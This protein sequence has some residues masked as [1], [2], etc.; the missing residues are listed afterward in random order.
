MNNNFYNLLHYYQ[1]ISLSKKLIS[2]GIITEN[3]SQQII[4][5]LKEHYKIT[6]IIDEN[7]MS[8]YNY[9]I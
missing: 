1:S 9:I 3:E 7:H 4:S 5:K 8:R 6:E 2:K